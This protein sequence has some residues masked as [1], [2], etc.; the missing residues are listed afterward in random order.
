MDII[1]QLAE[2]LKLKES[3]VKATVELIDGGNTIPFIARYRKE[4]TGSLDDNILRDLFDR[5]TYIRNLEKRKTEVTT[6][7]ETL[8]LLT[9]ELREE[10]SNSA[11]LT[12]VED[13]YRP[14]KPKRRTRASIAKE[15]GLE[16]LA[17]SIFQQEDNAPEAIIMAEAYVN[18]EKGV[19]TAEDALKGAVDIIAETISDDAAIR[20]ELRSYIMRY[21]TITS[22]GKT[23]DESVYSMYYDFS[24]TVSK[25]AGH[26]ILAMD[27]GERE[28]ILKVSINTDVDIAHKTLERH[29][30]TNPSS[31][32]AQVVREAGIDAFERL[33][34]PS[35]ENEVRN[36]LTEQAAELAI[37]LFATNLH[38]LLMQPPVKGNVALGLDPAYRTGCKIA[39]VDHTGKVLDTTVIYP[40][41]PQSKVEE[42]SK[43]IKN[44]IM[45]YGVSIIAI[46]NGTASKES[47]IFVANLI[48]ELDCN[49]AYMVVS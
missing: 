28:G 46:G 32:S 38:Q 16:P 37:K 10:I 39:V 36:F 27:R 11:T 33:I 17:T 19:L 1:K 14:F 2:E 26:R 41:P 40:T 43:T 35:I 31:N 5:L 44:L 7:I 22:K 13:I 9:D 15:K 3:Q 18:E 8:E 23:E 42:A 21:G 6:A 4:A 48:K 49:V 25:V 29:T 24:D 30:I 12:E 45:K 47:E 34:Y 20:R